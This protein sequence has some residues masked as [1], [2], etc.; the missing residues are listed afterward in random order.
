MIE[1]IALCFQFD[2]IEI[3][4]EAKHLR[5]LLQL[6]VI[7][8]THMIGNIEKAVLKRKLNADFTFLR[9]LVIQQIFCT[10]VNTHD[11]KH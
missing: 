9:N 7:S 11:W 2:T 1:L 3:P 10:K 5:R 6:I 4:K 8:S